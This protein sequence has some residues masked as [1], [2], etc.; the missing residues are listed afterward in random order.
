MT[1]GAGNTSYLLNGVASDKQLTKIKN[2]A[3]TIYLQ[4]ME[5]ICC[6]AQVR[7]VLTG[8]TAN[9]R[10]YGGVDYPFFSDV[11]DHGGNL[12]FTDGHAKFQKKSTIRYAQFG[13]PLALNQQY[14]EYLLQGTPDQLRNAHSTRKFYSDF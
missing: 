5:S 1:T 4:E 10:Q 3:D 14:G 9:P 2:P 8:G 7:P 11:H 6:T 12:L 13:F